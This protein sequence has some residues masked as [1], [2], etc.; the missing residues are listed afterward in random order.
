MTPIITDESMNRDKQVLALHFLYLKKLEKLT[1]AER[2]AITRFLDHLGR[3]FNAP[4]A[5]TTEY[6]LYANRDNQHKTDESRVCVV[7]GEVNV[8]TDQ[9]FCIKLSCSGKLVSPEERKARHE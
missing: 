4:V 5:V 7:C 6:S 2:N 8:N 9:D 3:P 1:T